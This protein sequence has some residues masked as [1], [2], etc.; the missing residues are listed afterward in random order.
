METVDSIAKTFDKVPVDEYSA[1]I[2]EP[3]SGK[4]S[5][6]SLADDLKALFWLNNLI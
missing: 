5:L 1:E 3:E 4:L 6:K 2:L